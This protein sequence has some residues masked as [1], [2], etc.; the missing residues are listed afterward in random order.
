MIKSDKLPITYI[1]PG[2]YPA[3]SIHQKVSMRV[4]D[5]GSCRRFCYAG[6]DQDLKGTTVSTTKVS[7][8]GLYFVTNQTHNARLAM[9]IDIPMIVS[10]PFI[11]NL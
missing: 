6:N 9:M 7:S 1:L 4:L 2:E 8:E 5:G 11:H 3:Q 10:I